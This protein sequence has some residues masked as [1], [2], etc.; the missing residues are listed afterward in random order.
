[1]YSPVLPVRFFRIIKDSL[2]GK[3]VQAKRVF[4]FLCHASHITIHYVMQVAHSVGHVVSFSAQNDRSKGCGEK[5]IKNE[6]GHEREVSGR[7]RRPNVLD[8]FESFLQN[9]LHPLLANLVVLLLGV[10]LAL[11]CWRCISL[12]L[13][14]T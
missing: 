3:I 6:L 14:Q 12:L 9:R 8:A 4:P 1:M 7:Q 11:L 2:N 13:G 10:G 5:E